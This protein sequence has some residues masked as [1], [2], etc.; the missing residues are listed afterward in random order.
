MKTRDVTITSQVMRGAV[1]LHPSVRIA[2]VSITFRLIGIRSDRRPTV[3]GG[4]GHQV[5]GP[6]ETLRYAPLVV[7]QPALSSP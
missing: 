1:L 2:E 3:V 6:D 4:L 7:H 5:L